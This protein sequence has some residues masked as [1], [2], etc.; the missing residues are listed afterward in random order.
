MHG[1]LPW[2]IR[3][4]IC[5]LLSFLITI[6]T[7]LSPVPAQ[8]A[9]STTLLSD[10]DAGG[11]V[12][13]A[14]FTWIVL[15]PD[16]G[17]LLMEDALED[18]IRFD[19]AGYSPFDP[20]RSTNIGYYLNNDF[21]KSLSASEQAMIQSHSWSNGGQGWED[22]AFVHGKIGMLAYSEYV[23]LTND[24]IDDSIVA[25]L[26]LDWWLRTNY[27]G[28]NAYL[29]VSSTEGGIFGN[30]VAGTGPGSQK[31]L[32]P[33]LYLP[34]DSLVSGG[35]ILVG[36]EGSIRD[37]TLDCNNHEVGTSRDL[38]VDIIT[39]N[40]P[41]GNNVTVSLT[42]KD[43]KELMP[44]VSIK[45]QIVGNAVNLILSLSD[46]LAAGNYFVMAKVEGVAKEEYLPYTVNHHA[47]DVSISPSGHNE[48][49]SQSVT[50]NITA[51]GMTDGTNLYITL[52]DNSKNA[53]ADV[54]IFQRQVLGDTA[55]IDLFLPQTLGAGDY[56]VKVSGDGMETAYVPYKIGKLAPVV[57]LDPTGHDF[58]TAQRVAVE[59]IT[60]G[61]ADGAGVTAVLMDS[62]NNP[63]AGVE[64]AGAILSNRASLTLLIPAAAAAGKYYVLAEVEGAQESGTAQYNIRELAPARCTVSLVANPVNGGTVRGGGTFAVGTTVTV[65]A[66]SNSSYK[67][68]NWTQDGQEVSNSATYTF[69][70]LGAD[71]IVFTANFQ[72]EKPSQQPW[73]MTL[74]PEV[75]TNSATDIKEGTATLNGRVVADGGA[76]CTEAIFRFRPVGDN[77]WEEIPAKGAV[78]SSGD[79]LSAKLKG[80]ATGTEYEFMAM[81]RNLQG[82]GTGETKRFF[83]AGAPSVITERAEYAD[84]DSAVI[85]GIVVSDGG[86]TVTESGFLFGPSPEQLRKIKVN[87]SNQEIL[88]HRLTNLVRNTKYYYRAYAA[89]AVGT[90]YGELQSFQT[91]RFLVITH[92]V[93]NIGLYSATF[94]GNV[95]RA[96]GDDTSVTGCGFRYG[97][98]TDSDKYELAETSFPDFSSQFTV[99]LTD[100]EPGT[101]YRCQ[102][103]AWDAY[104]ES[105]GPIV[106]FTT[107]T[108]QPTVETRIP[109]LITANT[110][111]L[112]GY[113]VK[114]NGLPI[115]QSGIIWGSEPEMKNRVIVPLGP[116]SRSFTYALTGIMP[117]TG[118][119]FKAFAT[120]AGGTGYGDVISFTTPP[121]LPTVITTDAIFCDSSWTGVLKG[122]VSDNGGVALSEYGFRYSKDE[123]EW[124]TIVLGE[125]FI[126]D[127]TS[128][129]IYSLS[130]LEPGN[131]Y[132]VQAYAANLGGTSYG[133]TL[134]FTTLSLPRLAGKIE[135]EVKSNS[136]LLSGEITDAG[137]EEAACSLRRF[138]YQEAGSELWAE[139]G[140]EE[141]TF[142]AGHFNFSLVGIRPGTVY[143]FQAGAKNFAGWGQSPIIGFVTPWGDDDKEAAVNL[144]EAGYTIVQITDFLKEEFEDTAAQAFSALQL[145]GFPLQEIAKALRF[146]DYE[147][148]AA[149]IVSIFADNGID[150]AIALDVAREYFLDPRGYAYQKADYNY[151]QVR[152]LV[153]GGYRYNDIADIIKKRLGIDTIESSMEYLYGCAAGVN[154]GSHPSQVPT[155]LPTAMGPNVDGQILKALE[156]VYGE[157]NLRDYLWRKLN[158]SSSDLAIYFMKQLGDDVYEIA[159]F[160]SNQGYGDDPGACAYFLLRFGGFNVADTADALRRIFGNRPGLIFNALLYDGRYTGRQGIYPAPLPDVVKYMVEDMKVSLPDMAAIMTGNRRGLYLSYNLFAERNALKLLHEQYSPTALELAQAL[161]NAGWTD[162]LVQSQDGYNLQT[163]VDYLRTG[164]G[165]MTARE[166]LKVLKHLGLSP[167]ILGKVMTGTFR[168]IEWTDSG[169]EEGYTATEVAY[170]YKSYLEDYSKDSMEVRISFTISNLARTKYDLRDIVLALKTAYE[171]EQEKA[172]LSIT[173]IS[174]LP[175]NGLEIAEAVAKVYGGDLDMVRII[176]D[177]M[178][179]ARAHPAQIVSTLRHVFEIDDPVK[180]AKYLYPPQSI[181]SEEEVIWAVIRAFTKPYT[182]GEALKLALDLASK[183]YGID[184]VNLMI[185]Q[186]VY[187][188]PQ[189]S[190]WDENPDAGQAVYVLRDAGYTLDQ[191]VKVLKSPPKEGYNLTAMQIQDLLNLGTYSTGKQVLS[192]MDKKYDY[193]YKPHEITAAI[194]R[195]FGEDLMVLKL[196]LIRDNVG[197][198]TVPTWLDQSSYSA[199]PRWVYATYLAMGTI[200]QYFGVTDLEK[201]AFNLKRAGFLEQEIVDG[202]SIY[203]SMS[204]IDMACLLLKNVFKVKDYDSFALKLKQLFE[205]YLG[206]AKCAADALKIAYPNINTSQTALALNRAGYPKGQIAMWLMYH[207][208][209]VKDNIVA[210]VLGSAKDGDIGFTSADAA[211][212]LYSRGYELPDAVTWLIKNN[213]TLKELFVSLVNHYDSAPADVVIALKP[214]YNIDQLVEACNYYNNSFFSHTYGY[215]V[216]AGFYRED[217]IVAM[218]KAHRESVVNLMSII[219]WHNR[220][221]AEEPG[222][223]VKRLTLTQIGFVLYN[224]GM[225][226]PELNIELLDIIRGFRENGFPLKDVYAST[227]DLTAQFLLDKPVEDD[228]GAKKV[229][230]DTLALYILR[231][232]GM[233]ADTAA[234]IQVMRRVGLSVGSIIKAVIGIEDDWKDALSNLGEAGYSFG[235]SFSAIW[236]NETYHLIIGVS[237]LS[238]MAAKAITFLSESKAVINAVKYTKKIAKYGFKLGEY[239]SSM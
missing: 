99:T 46:S 167:E 11:K 173:G 13:F 237:I 182:Y 153:Q 231:E 223:T 130:N 227:K 8:G 60:G 158:F 124:T 136:V 139:A 115:T 54:G 3:K 4:P 144:K 76:A 214:Y 180:I 213:Y 89:N 135:G 208:P 110:A 146:S 145:A 82:W 225:K 188:A 141:G 2:F 183:V 42:D 32:R 116:D 70:C 174:A 194:E 191:I 140:Q 35:N 154:Y 218:L 25:K 88:I 105:S 228:D 159:R 10:L 166:M 7:V 103:V 176:V 49:I 200:Y 85:K 172:L 127:Y 96:P 23:S 108:F 189:G 43:K 55:G 199:D 83:T 170:W 132:R 190:S 91:A 114:N 47:P 192:F 104:G 184:K 128:E 90:A 87:D 84:A 75:V 21:L 126:G 106:E 69:N 195:A 163:V 68:I 186:A 37:I 28:N 211:R 94:S 164:F 162:P 101:H 219:Y 67:F 118:Y 224:V 157:I 239:I 215:L 48:G 56:F 205:R 57:S 1:Y 165:D 9:D 175:W 121:N 51:S 71:D 129:N 41:N 134:S 97:T 125:D 72:K 210:A 31:A 193:G 33:T 112:N 168:S 209:Q 6:M 18:N 137:G 202:V 221:K 122:R 93:T 16:E 133:E 212:V 77:K 196:K 109:E 149:F 138:R 74:T 40:V 92:Q 64:A 24:G 233:D 5:V 26:S 29:Y 86:A 45:G 19:T 178:K 73:P 22:Q 179:T 12:N 220:I 61:V 169:K 17:Y 78:F 148:Q 238:Q 62:E 117:L 203:V 181:Y 66:E 235:D 95:F 226:N 34:S 81:A 36:A 177:Q 123:K 143:E 152:A 14:G 201:A 15:E 59:V 229:S 131:T 160:I 79:S 27:Q 38:G 150:I 50:V 119:Y 113:V 30:G 44:D 63:V 142:G 58:G 230:L 161:Y 120:N 207:T 222:S 52:V 217:V 107:P 204:P 151:L 216:D 206:D 39:N 171:L 232:A 156:E 80:L 111:D 234:E 100:L 98:G 65:T 53:V 147:A 197:A 155:R 187:G 198:Y 236:N 185:L 102:A 20:A